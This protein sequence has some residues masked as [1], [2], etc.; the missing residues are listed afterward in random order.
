MATPAEDLNAK[1]RQEAMFRPKLV[2]YN[3][4][5]VQDFTRKYAITGLTP[6]FSEYDEELSTIL[7]DHYKATG[8]IFSNSLGEEMPDDVSVTDREFEIIAAALL[9]HFL[10]RASKVSAEINATTQGD[11]ED[12]ISFGHAEREATPQLGAVE[13]AAIAGAALSRKLRGR[14]TA[15]VTTETQVPAEQSK[16]AEAE[17]LSGIPPSIS[18]GT[19]QRVEVTKEWVTVGDDLVRPAHVAADGAIVNINQPFKVGGEQLM[20]PGDESLG[21]TAGNIINCR[22]SAEYDTDEIVN[23]RQE[24]AAWQ[25]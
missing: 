12:A 11:A 13:T 1:L 10:T 20:V 2:A 4:R 6:D 14:L 23:L 22:C 21:A 15:T 19:L 3:Q 5:L 16:L 17:V 9:A 24:R 25:L 7:F 8:E 18:T